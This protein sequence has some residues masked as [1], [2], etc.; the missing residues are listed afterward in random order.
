M[1]ARALRRFPG[2]AE[3]M[4]RAGGRQG[5]PILRGP[6]SVHTLSAPRAKPELDIYACGALWWGF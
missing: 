1:I 4:D 3:K 5:L 2:S 6:P